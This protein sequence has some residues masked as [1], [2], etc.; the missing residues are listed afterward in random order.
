MS[1]HSTSDR[2]V[3]AET[4]AVPGTARALAAVEPAA[5]ARM[6]KKGRETLFFF[7]ARV[8]CI[9]G[10]SVPRVTGEES[11]AASVLR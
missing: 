11:H 7:S 6:K 1:D 4:Q 10:G 8:V 9:R 3:S 2:T 5:A